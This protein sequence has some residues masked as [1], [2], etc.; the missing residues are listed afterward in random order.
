MANHEQA[1]AKVNAQVD[2]GV[3]GI[4]NA[5]GLFPTLQTF[6]S[7]QG[8]SDAPAWVCF[9]FGDWERS[10]RETADFVLDFLAPKLY[11][12][13]GDSVS[14]SL[15]VRESGEILS[16]LSVRQGALETTEQ[17]LIELSHEFTSF[18]RRS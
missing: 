16:D 8:G 10:W 3:C 6:E 9:A 1:W 2:R 12:K 14:I 13:V 11:A 18:Q 17:I 15:R 7:C 5:L 4:V